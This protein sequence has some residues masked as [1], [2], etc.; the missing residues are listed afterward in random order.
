MIL[1]KN[2]GFRDSFLCYFIIIYFMKQ[3]LTGMENI[4]KTISELMT[5]E[6]KKALQ[7]VDIQ[8]NTQILLYLTDLTY[9]NSSAMA[10][11]QQLR[12]IKKLH[13]LLQMR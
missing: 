5:D 13:L 8:K 7:N 6:F 3:N 10:R 2:L 1:L 12:L 4:M 11:W 9:A